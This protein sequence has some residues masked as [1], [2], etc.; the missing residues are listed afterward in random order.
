[1]VEGLGTSLG[2][3]PGVGE[4]V[5]YC[6]PQ[7]HVLLSLHPLLT[8]LRG[9]CMGLPFCLLDFGLEDSGD[10]TETDCPRMC[11]PC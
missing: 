9:R 11:Y 6:G 7:L 3:Q 4:G 1:M 2:T 10:E 8:C 5:L